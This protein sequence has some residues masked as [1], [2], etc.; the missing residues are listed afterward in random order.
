MK[1]KTV[2]TCG[3]GALVALALASA[4]PAQAARNDDSVPGE[5]LLKLRSTAA[6][7]P[8]LQKYPITLI[9]G[10]GARPIYRV[11]L[12]GAADAKLTLAA[13]HTELDVLI[14]EPNLV[15]RPPEAA[16]NNVWA[17]GSQT[18]YTA[19]WAWS[20]LRL[21]ELGR[22]ATGAGVRVAVLDTGVD[23]AHPA[24]AGHLD[25][26]YDFVDGDTDP[27]EQ[28]TRLDA[29]FGHGTHVAGIIAR[30]APAA[31]II[32]MRVLDAQGAGDTWA[33]GEAMLRAV[34]PDG[35]PATDDGAQVINLSLGS[36]GRTRLLDAV[37]HLAQCGLAVTDDPV[38]DQ[39]DPGYGV[40]RERCSNS[41][42][43]VIVAAAGNEGSSSLRI[44]PAAEGAYGLVSVAASRADG[45]LAAFSNSGNWIDVAAPGDGLT[46]SVPGGGYGTW[47][48]TSMAAPVVA[49]TAALLRQIAPSLRAKEI[50]R[51]VV[52]MG[53]TVS[54]S[55]MRALDP[56]KALQ[57]A[58]RNGTC[59]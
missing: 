10:F 35:N 16:K 31:R 51:C 41:S 15:Q 27:T 56:L 22:I 53:G 54:G 13:L 34:D 55:P 4:G 43:A 2:R 8:L 12:I 59:R 21:P 58:A 20:A 14:A 9:A 39:S 42:G 37:A 1:R 5:L 7:P 3:A 47:S 18:G 19:Q 6:L 33:I 11:A 17:I 36:I 28:G 40:D 45:R 30:I 52:R 48:G 38:T 26:G 24:L 32:P 44:Y 57:T 25:P 46:S 50:K 29:A 49:A 23:A